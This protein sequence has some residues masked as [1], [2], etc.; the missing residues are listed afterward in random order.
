MDKEFKHSTFTQTNNGLK[1]WSAE[2][3]AASYLDRWQ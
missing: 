1:G 2:M 3:P